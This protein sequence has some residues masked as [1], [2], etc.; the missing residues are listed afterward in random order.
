[1]G[2]FFTS[3]GTSD[4][5]IE[6]GPYEEDALGVMHYRPQTASGEEV[7]LDEHLAIEP[8]DLRFLE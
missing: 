5:A 4:E 6:E 1:L 7:V 2:D 3:A 8:E